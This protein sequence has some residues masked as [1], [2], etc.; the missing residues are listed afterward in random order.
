MS[1][2][3]NKTCK[4][5]GSNQFKIFRFS[6]NIKKIPLGLTR[7]SKANFEGY[8]CN[9]C[10][11]LENKNKFETKKY[12]EGYYSNIVNYER[13]KLEPSY[14][15][16]GSLIEK[17]KKKGVKKILDFGSGDGMFALYLKKLGYAVDVLEPDPGYTKFLQNKFSKVY[18]DVSQVDKYY[19][20]VISI[21][22]LEHLNE[23]I[24]HIK[25]ICNK[26][27]VSG[28]FYVAQFPNISGLGARLS[29]KNWD[30]IY[31]SGHNY[32]PSAT[33][34]K[35]FFKNNKKHNIEVVDSFSS[36]ITSRGRIPW[37]PRRIYF[38]EMYYKKLLDAFW[39]FSKLNKFLWSLQ[40]IP[41]LGETIIV[42]FKKT[43]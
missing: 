14:D 39:F 23:P 3:I 17:L 11:S 38:L 13:D 12:T 40:D 1:N 5:C 24:D 10:N 42:I 4:F 22:V 7:G 6:S 2:Q 8:Q 26:V 29:I 33:G 41:N 16:T 28:G 20:A 21:G 32:I 37:L 30:M 9:S 36:S 19:D 43:N 18:Q 27:L 35:I 31:E 34:L 25:E 15:Y